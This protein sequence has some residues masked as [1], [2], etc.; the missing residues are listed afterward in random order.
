MFKLK[1]KWFTSK[2]HIGD[3]VVHVSTRQ[4][5]R[6]VELQSMAGRDL[7]SVTLDSGHEISLADRREFQL[8]SKG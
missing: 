7:I 3:R 5:G 1:G 2:Y 8:A 4:Y 6:V